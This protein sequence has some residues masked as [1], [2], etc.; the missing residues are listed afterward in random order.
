MTSKTLNRYNSTTL[1]CIR[2]NL[3][4]VAKKDNLKIRNI[5]FIM[6]F[7]REVTYI[8]TYTLHG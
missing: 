3:V 8:H 2:T 5:N 1:Y 7:Y 4:P 6:V